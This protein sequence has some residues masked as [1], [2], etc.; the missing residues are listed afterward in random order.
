MVELVDTKDLKSFVMCVLVQVR[1]E[2]ITLKVFFSIKV[3]LK[4]K[5]TKCT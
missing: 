4:F 2:V 5:I 3:F 1:L